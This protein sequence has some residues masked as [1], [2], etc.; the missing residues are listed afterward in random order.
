[1]FRKWYKQFGPLLILHL[2]RIVIKEILR[3]G[4]CSCPFEIKFSG[5][6]DSLPDNAQ[7]D[8]VLLRQPIYEGNFLDKLSG[9][10]YSGITRIIILKVRSS[11][12]AA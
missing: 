12:K 11:S 1:M 3:A 2:D 4:N 8:S 5:N 7:L 10:K 6:I 9:K